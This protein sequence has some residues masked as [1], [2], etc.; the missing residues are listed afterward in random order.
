MLG[1][2]EVQSQGSED[3]STGEID[4]SDYEDSLDD[5]D[6]ETTASAAFTSAVDCIDRLFRLTIKVRDPSTR[7]G[8]SKGYKFRKIDEDS[9]LDLYDCFA[10]QH[11]DESFVREIL[12]GYGSPQS[13]T[14]EPDSYL[15]LRLA[16]ANNQR[17]R[18]FAYWSHHKL[19]LAERTEK[20]RKTQERQ[21]QLPTLSHAPSATEH[22]VPTTATHFDQKKVSID[23]ETRSNISTISMTIAER[24]DWSEKFTSFPDPPVKYLDEE[25]LKE[26]ECPYCYTICSAKL[27][28]KRRWR[29]VEVHSI[30]KFY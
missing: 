11:I 8:L 13:S 3:G 9:G 27:L 18:Q 23:D 19:K 25:D 4:L 20:A 21:V 12:R 17:R 2:A 30:V 6:D 1:E 26:F 22:S 7:T 16:K 29:Y 28:N 10:E 5:Y 24:A 14:G 15:V